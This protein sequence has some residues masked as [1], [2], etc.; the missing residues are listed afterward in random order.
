MPG[1]I[2][3]R[4]Q[5]RANPVLRRFDDHRPGVLRVSDLLE[6]VWL[7]KQTPLFADVETEDLQLIA[8][9]LDEET[10]VAGERLFDRGDAGDRAYFIVRGRISIATPANVSK[11]EF[12]ATRGEHE[13]FGEL[14]LLDDRPRAASAHVV[15]D[16]TLLALD[17]HKFRALIER[18]P[19]LALGVLRGFGARLRAEAPGTT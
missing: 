15:R 18:Y 7:L 3:A 13:C 10:C 16:A 14:C 9:E 8:Q 6:R 11:A 17:R 19:A 1:C 4:L 2:T 12:I 5:H